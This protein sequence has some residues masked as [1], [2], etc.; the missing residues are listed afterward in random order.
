M[1]GALRAYEHWVT[2]Y[3]RLWRASIVSSVLNPVLYLTALGV[4][5]GKLVNHGP[6]PLGVSY[7][8]FVA[9]GVLAATGMQIA[10]NESSFPV[11]AAL[12]WTRTYYAMLASP[13]RVRDILIGHQLYFA[14]RVAVAATIYLAALAAFGTLHSGYAIFALPVTVLVGAAFS[15]PVAAFSAWAP[16]DAYLSALLRFGI[17]PMFLFSGTFFPVTRLPP[18][19]REIAYA[20]PLWHGVDL[21]RHLTL[22]TAT[23]GMSLVHV[24]YLVAFAGAG[25]VIAE[26]SYRKRLVL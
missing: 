11:M 19:V 5:L 24:A 20:T 13:L 1:D 14:S 18:G 15:A 7:V 2:S 25:L 12:R 21:A 8:A 9:P 4:G 6:H 10:T 26:R 17:V 16:K 23:W 22:G 3:R